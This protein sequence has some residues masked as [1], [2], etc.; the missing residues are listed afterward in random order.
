M[1]EDK[2]PAHFYTQSW[3]RL[4]DVNYLVTR[5]T[6]HTGWADARYQWPSEDEF[7][8]IKIKHEEAY[9]E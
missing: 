3:E 6:K 4:G 2:A 7:R 5:C 9:P 8:K 1:P